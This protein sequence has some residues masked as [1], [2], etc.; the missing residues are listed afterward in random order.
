M[1]PAARC[2]GTS[3]APANP[4]H[5]PSLPAPRE[6]QT[7]QPETARRG[8]PRQRSLCREAVERRWPAVATRRHPPGMPLRRGAAVCESC[9]AAPAVAGRLL[10]GRSDRIDPP[11]ASA[12]GRLGGARPCLCEPAGGVPHLKRHR[13]PYGRQPAH[14]GRPGPDPWPIGSRECRRKLAPC[15]WRPT[16]VPA[17]KPPA[18]VPRIGF[19]GRGKHRADLRERMGS[20]G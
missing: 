14:A 15:R 6:Q 19:L 10:H 17:P 4:P 9:R 1:L 3:D 16:Q 2:G 18:C 7:V 13:S 8:G 20:A 11:G 12:G 5:N